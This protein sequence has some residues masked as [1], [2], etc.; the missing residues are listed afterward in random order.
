VK[1][2][3]YRY[4]IEGE[5]LTIAE[6]VARVPGIKPDTVR[7][8]VDRGARTWVLLTRPPG[9]GRQKQREATKL[10]VAAGL[11]RSSRAR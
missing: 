2:A 1:A 7:D 6:I 5:L 4:T 8:R 10:R 11:F 3:G 9:V